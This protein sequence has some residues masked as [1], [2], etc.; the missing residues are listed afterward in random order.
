MTCSLK[1]PVMGPA[2]HIGA[3]FWSFQGGLEWFPHNERKNCNNFEICR[4]IAI[5]VRLTKIQK[6]FEN[7]FLNLKSL[8]LGHFLKFL[9]PVFYKHPQFYS[10]KRILK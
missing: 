4:V 3:I 5:F 8:L 2:L 10:K 6:I 1:I 7:I 9:G